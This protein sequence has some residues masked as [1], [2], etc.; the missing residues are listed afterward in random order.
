MIWQ[1]NTTTT[2]ISPIQTSVAIEKNM[3]Q[4]TYIPDPKYQKAVT[5]FCRQVN[6]QPKLTIDQVRDAVS[7]HQL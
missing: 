4:F 3:I 5:M 2:A 7:F 1:L 6:A